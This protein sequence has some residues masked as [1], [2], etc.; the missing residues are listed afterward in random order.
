MAMVYTGM[1]PCCESR[2]WNTRRF[3]DVGVLK[4]LH[5]DQQLDLHLDQQLDLHPDLRD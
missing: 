3:T 4:S 1:Q 5:L 2:I